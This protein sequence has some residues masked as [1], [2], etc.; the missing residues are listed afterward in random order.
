MSHC[1]PCTTGTARL[2]TEYL[3]YNMETDAEDKFQEIK[4]ASA[5]YNKVGTL[6]VRPH[7]RYT[8][9]RP[10]SGP[11]VYILA[12]HRPN[13][14]VFELMVQVT[15]APCDES[16]NPLDESVSFVDKEEDIIGKPW[17]ARIR[18]K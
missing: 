18:I 15:W 9:H 11:F 5:P 3:I 6:E 16:G 1:R 4:N 8:P 2:Y 10:E 7:A 14:D 12:P 13:I 17:N